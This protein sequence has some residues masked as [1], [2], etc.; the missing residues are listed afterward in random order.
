MN[1]YDPVQ[2]QYRIWKFVPGGSCEDLT[3]QWDEATTTLTITNN[4]GDGIT[5]KAAFHVIDR[6]HREYDVVAK[7]GDGK[8]YMDIHG[9]VSRRK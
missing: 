3:G 4:L 5:V 8:I 2:K 7:D 6:D 9:S 1:S